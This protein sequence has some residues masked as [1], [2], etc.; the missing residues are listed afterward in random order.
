[1]ATL[2]L[3]KKEKNCGS[4][5]SNCIINK[6]QGIFIIIHPHVYRDLTQKR[7]FDKIIVDNITV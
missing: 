4:I 5:T 2:I 1:M 7:K 6:Y 3:A